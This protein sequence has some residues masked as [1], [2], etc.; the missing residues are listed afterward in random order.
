[1]VQQLIGRIGGLTIFRLPQVCEAVYMSCAIYFRIF[2]Y[3]SPRNLV[4]YIFILS[5]LQ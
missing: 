1:M 5:S 3:F 2:A 4:L